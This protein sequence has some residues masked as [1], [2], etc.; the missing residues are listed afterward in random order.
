M[1]PLPVVGDGL[2]PFLPTVHAR[3]A[4]ALGRLLGLDGRVTLAEPFTAGDG[5]G[6]WR[7]CV[8]WERPPAAT[9]R[10]ELLASGPE[11]QGFFRGRHVTLGYRNGPGGEDP[12]SRPGDRAA[13]E[14]LR[15]RVR[16]LDDAG[17]GAGPLGDFLAEFAALRGFA[18]LEDRT[19]RYVTAREAIVRLGFRCNQRCD[20]CW[21]ARDWPEPPEELYRA[22][23]DE[24][25]ARGV[26]VLHLTGGEPTLHPE[27]PAL[28][29]RAKEAHGMEVWLQTNAVRLAKRP[30]LDA[31]VAAGLDGIFASH[32]AHVAEV[33]DAMTSAPG[34][35]AYT[36][37]GIAAAL[38]AGVRV[39]INTLV[40]RRNVALLAAHARHLVDVFDTRPGNRL[41]LVSYS[42]PGSYLREE[43]YRARLV[44]LDELRP[45]LVEAVRTLRARGVEVE[46]SGACGFPSCAFHGAPD[47][48]MFTDPELQTPETAPDRT[49][50]DA[51]ARCSA[52]PR[53]VGLRRL[54]VKHLGAR[55]VVPFE[56]APR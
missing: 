34:T 28:V 56:S 10:V 49:Y 53:C 19:F 17:A 13:L 50:V 39:V 15:A 48:A 31:L 42:H 3:V 1:R 16:A 26:R 40:E 25:G 44:P 45:H 23:V 6:G 51:C 4:E 12:W 41:R 24:L 21:Q 46:A 5:V 20:F 43:D 27:L 36:E 8:A 52:Q 38:D 54:Y 29:R 35:H 7:V 22:W 37:R 33:S 14:A 32:H 47:V 11:A 55:G 2:T 18:A 30:Y 9:L